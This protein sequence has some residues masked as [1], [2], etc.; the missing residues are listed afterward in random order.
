[1]VSNNYTLSLKKTLEFF[2]TLCVFAELVL[3]FLNSDR[4]FQ[5]SGYYYPLF[6]AL[7]FGGLVSLR[8]KTVHINQ[9]LTIIFVFYIMLICA[10]NGSYNAGYLYSYL[11]LLLFFYVMNSDAISS[12]TVYRMVCFYIIGAMIIVLLMIVFRVRYYEEVANRITIQVLGRPKIDPNY[13]AA[14]LVGPAVFSLVLY[15][16]LSKKVFI[17]A[18]IF[19]AVGILLTGSRAA[20]LALILALLPYTF[21]IRKRVNNRL[22]FG[23]VIVLFFVIFVTLSLTSDIFSR[24]KI[25]G[26]F[27]G[28]NYRRVELWGN[29]WEAIMQRPIFGYG[30]TPSS[31]IIG[32]ATGEYGPAHNT[33]LE[34]WL[35]TGMIGLFFMFF[36][37]IMPVLR[38]PSCFSKS[39]LI[40]TLFTVLMISAEATLFFW[41]NIVFINNNFI[42][43]NEYGVS[44][45][46]NARIQY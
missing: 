11:C 20:L 33:F 14:Y 43:S 44:E 32:E 40:G 36:F 17:Y 5:L 39:I 35:Q 9:I 37:I 27:D 21:Y 16:K 23:V 46:N 10:F 45:Y 34:I 22:L 30:I 15:F 19:I 31:Q 12:K 13:L 1:M 7:L 38:N 41:I 4:Y 26:L 3:C 42:R 6:G 2:F 24:F 18:F 8:Q 28:S 29:A 25:S